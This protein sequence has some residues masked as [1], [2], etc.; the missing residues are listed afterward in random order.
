MITKHLH[1]ELTQR[2][3]VLEGRIRTLKQKLCSGDG[4][5]KVNGSSTLLALEQRHDSLL[6]R[7]RTLDDEGPGFRQNVKAEIIVMADDLTA[8]VD[9]MIVPSHVAQ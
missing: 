8:M 6:E 2:L 3:H 7:T 5:E 9:S 4:A 1:P